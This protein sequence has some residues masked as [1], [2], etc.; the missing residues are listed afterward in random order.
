MSTRRR[1]MTSP[2]GGGTSRRRSGRAAA[3]RAGSRRGSAAQL[4][5]ELG[6]RCLGGPDAHR[7][8]APPTRRRRRAR[9]QLE[10]LLDVADAGHV[11]EVTGSS[12]SRQRARIGQR[13]VLVARRADGPARAGP[14][15]RSGMLP[16]R[17]LGLRSPLGRVAPFAVVTSGSPLSV[18][19]PMSADPVHD[20]DAAW[21]LLT[22][23]TQSEA[24]LRHALA[25]EASVRAYA[26]R[27]RRGRGRVGQRRPAARL[28]L[29]AAPHARPPPGGRRA[30]LREHGYPDG[31]SRACCRTVTISTWPAR[32]RSRRRSTPATRSRAS[33]TPAALVRPDGLATWSRGRCARS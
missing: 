23:C 7:R 32:R 1:P 13:G 15:P 28:R 10:H 6:A 29:R 27:G 14:R 16:R 24:L 18:A 12:V 5:I 2:P 19:P 31:S 25:V 26:R 30:V 3:R 8:S 21:A 9:R 20:R 4:R 11:L 22:E 33:S 17:R